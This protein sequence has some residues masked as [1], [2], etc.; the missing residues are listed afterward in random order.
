MAYWIVPFG[1]ANLLRKETVMVFQ[2]LSKESAETKLL[3]AILGLRQVGYFGV[4]VK[5]MWR[6]KASTF[7]S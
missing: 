3:L 7:I 2:S 4:S 1:I 5:G 6:K